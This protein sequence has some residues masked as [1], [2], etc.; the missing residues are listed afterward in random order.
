MDPKL[1]HLSILIT[2]NL[3]M[4]VAPALLKYKLQCYK[5]DPTS[6]PICSLVVLKLWFSLMA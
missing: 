1:G 6:S 5:R 3:V 4:N 2:S